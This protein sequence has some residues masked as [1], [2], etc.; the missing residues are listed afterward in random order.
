MFHE[1]FQGVIRAYFAHVG[2]GLR[3]GLASPLW[4]HYSTEVLECQAFFS[5][6]FIFFILAR[7]G[8]GITLPRSPPPRAGIPALRATRTHGLP[9]IQKSFG[10]LLSLGWLH[11]S[12]FSRAC[13]AFLKKNCN[14]PPFH[15]NAQKRDFI[16]GQLCAKFPLDFFVAV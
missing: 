7:G 15:Q 11:Y 16:W 3:R 8:R 4:L 14:Y 12:T 2:F 5:F 1:P 6:F 13:Q 9:S 10:A